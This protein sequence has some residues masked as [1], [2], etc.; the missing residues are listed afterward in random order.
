MIVVGG[1]LGGTSALREILKR[2]PEDF[3]LPIAVVLHRH[4]DSESLLVPVVQRDSNLPVS[5]ADDK[6]PIEAGRVYLAPANYH[7]LFEDNTLALSTDEP[8][9]FA[10][11]S[12]DVL[13]DSAAEWMRRNLVAV[14]LSGSGSDGAKGARHVE[15]CGGVVLVQEP[16]TAEAMWMPAAAIAATK[17]ARVMGLPAIAEELVRIA[18]ASR[19]GT[20]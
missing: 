1:S 5:E 18:A 20:T 12:V 15:E 11:P 10:R 3:P 2:L 7:M 13:F 9:N 4:R 6:E 17:G 14:I 19:H 8:V 16:G